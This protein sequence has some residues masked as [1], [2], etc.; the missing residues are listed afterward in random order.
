MLI[1]KKA[2][3]TELKNS[4]KVK[5]L[6]FFHLIEDL[7][8]LKT[9]G[10]FYA[11]EDV[12]SISGSCLTMK[13][14]REQLCLSREW[15]EEQI[16]EKEI[17]A[18]WIV[19]RHV[20]TK[21]EKYLFIQEEMFE[22]E[23]QTIMWMDDD[24]ES[25]CAEGGRVIYVRDMPIVFEEIMHRCEMIL[26]PGKFYK[27]D[28]E[29]FRAKIGD[30]LFVLLY[31]NGFNQV[32]EGRMEISEK[33]RSFAWAGEFRSEYWDCESLKYMEIAIYYRWFE[34]TELGCDDRMYCIW[35]E[36]VTDVYVAWSQ[37]KRLE[38]GPVDEI[39][40]PLRTIK[41]EEEIAEYL[42][43]YHNLDQVLNLNNR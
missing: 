42:R 40:I 38:A 31:Q 19:F 30:S 2:N 39:K 18:I 9:Q 7:G 33:E 34:E 1:R 26:V 16:K 22:D 21:E 28:F 27:L 6:T 25:A 10:Y 11:R 36:A 37:E 32:Q 35:E 20:I 12:V 23:V 14:E 43:H 24:Y 15:S 41:A 13:K 17:T 8:E 3:E 29:Q 4:R 5:P